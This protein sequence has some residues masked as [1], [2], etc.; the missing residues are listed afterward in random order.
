MT[1]TRH[2]L[3]A[4]CGAGF[5]GGPAPARQ[6]GIVLQNGADGFCRCPGSRFWFQSGWVDPCGP[7]G[8]TASDALAI[9]ID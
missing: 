7:Q 9:F 5:F 4:A 2:V 1:V 6:V 8:V 3:A